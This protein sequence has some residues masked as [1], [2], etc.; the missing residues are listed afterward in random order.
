[1]MDYLHFKILF[2]PD[3]NIHLNEWRSPSKTA[4]IQEIEA[5]GEDI[6]ALNDELM[7]SLRLLNY[8]KEYVQK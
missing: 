5:S 3:L 8:E 7:D 2:T 1:M 6:T 4:P